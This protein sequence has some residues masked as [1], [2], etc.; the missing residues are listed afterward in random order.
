MINMKI[1]VPAGHVGLSLAVLAFCAACSTPKMAYKFDYH[2]YNAGRKAKDVK[3]EVASNP[4]PLPV[5]A[6]SLVA[7]DP[8]N[9]AP[10]TSIE[11]IEKPAVVASGKTYEDMS[12]KE[13]RELR[14]EFKKEIKSIVKKENKDNPTS[15]E[16]TKALDKDLKLAA[17]FGAVGIVGLILGGASGVFWVIGGVAMLI[18]VVFFVKWLIRQ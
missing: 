8:I 10:A 9:E 16:A 18:G 13:R 15:V 17:I 11:S 3:E 4:G 1:R 2:D 12:K 6:E 14:R 7:M 5:Q